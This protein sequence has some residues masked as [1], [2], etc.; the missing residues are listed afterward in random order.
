M[1]RQHV[2]A[3]DGVRGVA[4][5][6]VLAFHLIGGAHAGS[7]LI[8]AVASICSLGWSG[9]TLFFILSGFLITGIL[10]DNRHQKSWWKSFYMRRTLRIAPLYYA[11]LLIVLLTAIFAGNGIFA[12]SR[13]WVYALYLQ[14]IPYFATFA[15]SFGSSLFL[16]HFWS[17]AVEEQF[18]LVWPLLIT[19]ARSAHQAKYLCLGIFVLSLLFRLLCSRRLGREYD[20]FLPVRAGELAFGAYLSFCVQAKEWSLFQRVAPYLLSACVIS[21]LV[22]LP[23]GVLLTVMTL[24][25]GSFLTLSL[26][27][28]LIHRTM[29]RPSLRWLGKISYGLYVFHVLFLPVYWGVVRK[30]APHA[31]TSKLA[32]L[33]A[34][35]DI[36]LSLALATLSFRYFETPFLKLR[37]RFQGGQR[38]LDMKAA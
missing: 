13:L 31:G 18:Y 11:T 4:I 20:G 1:S 35:I 27:T 28:G 2:P 36:V 34:L 33:V 21:A 26:G 29:T 16:F 5:L 32:P 8:R 24:L 3:L 25:W 14:N 7:V 22:G 19:R 30:L 37:K 38:T 9:V 15:S 12:V 6:A 10:W 23:Q 17:L